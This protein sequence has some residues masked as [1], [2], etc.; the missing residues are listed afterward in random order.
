MSSVTRSIFLRNRGFTLIEL[1]ASIVLI[2]IT[3]TLLFTMI[4]PAVRQ[5][6]IPLVQT[7]AT[8]FAQAIMDDIISKRYDE[9]TA[10]GGGI[11]SPC[12]ASLGA[13]SGETT[14]GSFD[15]VDDY[16][17]YCAN[18]NSFVDVFGNATAATGYQF[19]SCIMYDGD[20]DG[21]ADSNEN[22]KLIT[23]TVY[24]PGSNSNGIAFS[25]YRGN[26]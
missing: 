12:S 5:G 26:Y 24:L 20:Y 15:D 11:C 17:V 2:G 22:A 13:D 8:Q 6:S 19:Q 9:Q 7:R 18:L 4:F 16:N 25:S 23:V 14:R 21:V 10:V 3:L 1:V